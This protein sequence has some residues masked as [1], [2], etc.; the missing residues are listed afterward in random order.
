LKH[1]FLYLLDVQTEYEILLFKEVKP[2][3]NNHMLLTTIR[4]DDRQEW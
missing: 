4:A 2:T 1:F 3:C